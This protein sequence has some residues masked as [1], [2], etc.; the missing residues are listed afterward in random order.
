YVTRKSCNAFNDSLSNDCLMKRIDIALGVAASV[1]AFALQSVAGSGDEV[2]VLFNSRLPESKALADYY[3]ERRQV[4]RSQIHGFQVTTNEDVSRAEFHDSLQM[5]LA[6]ILEERKLWRFEAFRAPAT[7]G[8]STRG[9]RKV[10]ESKIRYA[11]LCYGLPLKILRDPNL[12][13]ER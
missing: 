13:E 9:E 4:P 11:V 10:V 1:S 12:K 7:N 2:V 8:N 6:K 5:P 3:A